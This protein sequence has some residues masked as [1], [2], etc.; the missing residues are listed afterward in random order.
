M[1][2]NALIIKEKVKNFWGANINFQAVTFN[3]DVMKKRNEKPYEV[4]LNTVDPVKSLYDLPDYIVAFYEIGNWAYI[5]PPIL[6]FG[7]QVF[8]FTD[9]DG[10]KIIYEI[11]YLAEFWEPDTEVRMLWYCIDSD[12]KIL[13]PVNLDYMDGTGNCS[14]GIKSLLK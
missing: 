2:I 4:H 13:D 5:R 12:N 14:G 3:F 1:I 6:E 11:E 10:Y 7:T 9:S 8:D